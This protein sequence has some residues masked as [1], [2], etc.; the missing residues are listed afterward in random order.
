MLFNSLEFLV[1]LLLVLA[2]YYGA[3]PRRAWSARKLML[4]VASY[5]FYMNW[6]PYFGGILL[7]STVCDFTLG[8]L[9]EQ[10][11]TPRRRRLCVVASVC[12]N[13]G[14]LCFFK[15]GNFLLTNGAALL[16]AIAVPVT[17][18]TLE[19]ALP[20]GISFY[21][22]ESLSYVID[23]YRGMPASRNFLNF[24]LF[25]SFFPHL[26]AGPIVRPAAFLP[27]LLRAP[28][29]DGA[30]IEAALARIGTGLVKKVV[31]AD[32]FGIYADTVW[33][34]ARPV[35]WLNTLLGVYSYA[36]QIYFDFSGYTDIAL[37][38][39]ML[40]GLSLPENFDRPYLATSPRD[41]WR[42]WHIS[43]STWLRDYLYIPLGGNRRSVPRTHVNLLLTMLL[44]G[45]WHGAAW[46]FVLWGGYHGLLLSVQHVVAPGS[47]RRTPSPARLWLQRILTFHLVCFGWILFRSP[48]LPDVQ[49][50]LTGL[51]S[52]M[53]YAPSRAASLALILL[54]IA[55]LLHVAGTGTG[56][57]RWFVRLP[58]WV[59][60]TAYAAMVLL[61]FFFSPRTEGFIYFQF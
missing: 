46:N 5:L 26:V 22:F 53:S 27:Q 12:L 17:P 39:A 59:Q 55:V 6:N 21:T 61:V 7:A 20:I 42:R 8:R 38:L 51:T 45:L 50:I 57:R 36:F 11:T 41:F 40:F 25:L 37:G 47:P 31:F 33:E 14:I 2:V 58:A 43:L 18:P 1:F 19:I 15:Y 44:G 24:A 52:G 16:S 13:L 49:R 10:A 30:V 23:V 48:S 54:P 35:G 28:R 32:T 34:T 29:V 3:I 9:I 4:V 56:A 60:G